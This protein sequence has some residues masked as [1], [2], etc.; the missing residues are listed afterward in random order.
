MPQTP[1]ELEDDQQIGFLGP[2]RD[3]LAN[4]AR[5]CPEMFGD[6]LVTIFLLTAVFPAAYH[7]HQSNVNDIKQG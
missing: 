4:G 2:L 5:S 7:T 1:S 6:N 3:E